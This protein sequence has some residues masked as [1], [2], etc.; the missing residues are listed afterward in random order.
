DEA[1]LLDYDVNKARE[2]LAEAGYP[3]GENFPV[4]RLLIN[5]N[6]QQR[7]V[8]QSIAAMWRTALNIQTDVVIQSWEDYELAIQAGDYDVVRRGVV[9]QTTSEPTNLAMLFGRDIQSVPTAASPTE[10]PASAATPEPQRTT[11]IESE[12]QAL[13]ELKAMPIYFAS[14]YSL[15]K[16]YV[17]GFDLNVLDVP[18]LKRTRV[19]TNWSEPGR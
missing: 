18:S 7:L 15:V 5:R 11:V 14:S 4:V 19:D 3:N 16:P 6:E 10:S 8:A 17:S 1:E 9:M 12:A 2:L 13:K